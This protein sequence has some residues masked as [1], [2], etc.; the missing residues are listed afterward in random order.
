MLEM[1]LSKFVSQ[2]RLGLRV[3]MKTF[4]SWKDLLRESRMGRTLSS[5]CMMATN[6]KA[7][8]CVNK[9]LVVSFPLTLFLKIVNKT[10]SVR[11]NAVYGSCQ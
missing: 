2:D 7:L 3:Q 10:R 11:V 5:I 1:F 8:I 6:L 9:P 4:S